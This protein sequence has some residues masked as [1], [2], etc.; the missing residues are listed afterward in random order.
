M[1]EKSWDKLALQMI[2]GCLEG[3][4][5]HTAL[6]VERNESVSLEVASVHYLSLEI[7][8]KMAMVG[9]N[10]LMLL[11]I[12]LRCSYYLLLTIL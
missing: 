1:Q 8:N 5:K 2:N 9:S 6:V 3:E 4:A 10:L 7:W 11:I 12:I